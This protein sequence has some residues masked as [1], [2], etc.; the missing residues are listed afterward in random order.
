MFQI[1]DFIFSVDIIEKKFKCDLAHCH[2]HCCLEGDAGAPLTNDEAKILEEIYPKI[3]SYLRK[4][5]I[6]VIEKNGTSEVDNRDGEMVTPLVNNRECVYAVIENDMFFCA[7]EKA[8][9]DGVID[10][11][12]PISCHLYPIRVKK[13]DHITAV[14]YQEIELCECARKMGGE[15]GVY[16]YQFLKE[17]LIRAFGEKVYNDICDAAIE[18]KKI[19]YKRGR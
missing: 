1:D 4:E 11:R 15:E 10:F 16:V 18:L 12:K 2:G 8:W 3:K 5:G 14:N 19:N 9:Q 17:P 7:I 13:F 6:E